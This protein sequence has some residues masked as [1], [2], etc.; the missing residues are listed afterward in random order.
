M[1]DDWGAGRMT[2]LGRRRDG[3][4]DRAAEVSVASDLA[5]FLVLATE[6]NAL[7]QAIDAGMRELEHAG[8]GSTDASRDT[9]D[10]T[11]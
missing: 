5:E 11:Q 1:P 10:A 7:R 9:P 2:W 3:G 8:A 4:D 6:E